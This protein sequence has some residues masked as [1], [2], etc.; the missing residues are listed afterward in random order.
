LELPP[1][2]HC[3]GTEGGI[4]KQGESINDEEDLELANIG[5]LKLT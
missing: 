5:D 1:G 4:G 2:Q 3:T